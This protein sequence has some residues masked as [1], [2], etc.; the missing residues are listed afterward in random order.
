[1]AKIQLS[2]KTTYLPKWG[3][4]EGIRELV[5]NGRDAEVEHGATLSVD[6]YNDT[7]R[8]ENEGTVLEQRALLLGH[9]TKVGRSDM[10][11]QFGEG[12][13]LGVLALVRQGVPVKIR[14]GSEVWVPTIE[15]SE[16]FDEDVL[17]FRIET[18][19]ENK[20]RVRIEVGNVPRS[21][22]ESMKHKFLFIS[23]PKAEEQVT[24]A[25]GTLLRG[26]KYQG[27]VY[28]KGIFVQKAP[29]MKYGYDLSQGELDRDRKMV[30][31]WNLRYTTKTILSDAVNR[32]PSL[33]E[34][35]SEML[36]EPTLEVEGFDD[37][38]SAGYLSK[39]VQSFVSARFT[40][41]YGE[42]AVPVSS[43]AE[44]KD[45]EHL[46]MKGIVVRKPLQAVL[47]RVLGDMPAI[48]DRLEKEVQRTY[49][50]TDLSE[51]ERAHFTDA[52][53]TL[54]LGLD[55]GETVNEEFIDI[56]DFRSANLNGQFKEGRILL[57][58]KLLGD[59]EETLATLVHEFAHQKGEDGDHSHIAAIEMIWM[60]IVKGLKL[61]ALRASC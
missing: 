14:T 38:Y 7:L 20:N 33:C 32:E 9:T 48:K 34:A 36:E 11:G 46:G 45:I 26:A 55:N 18:G 43:L 35:F 24:T 4:W 42:N 23:K 1:M 49:S 41:K 13:K 47:S 57:A 60:R 3:V 21:E 16:Q 27:H 56:V 54:K 39:E 51:V 29:D 37:G 15:R 59:P 44:S 31:S 50:W 5:Q 58:K 61:K 28:V 22:W 12:L 30:E 52:V 2:I 53:Q 17:T 19:R 8:I 6:W 10:I 25:T 40:L